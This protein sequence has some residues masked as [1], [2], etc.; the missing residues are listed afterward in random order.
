MDARGAAERCPP[1]KVVAHM[2]AGE[3]LEVGMT[4]TRWDRPLA[5]IVPGRTVVWLVA[6]LRRDET[7]QPRWT[8]ALFIYFR[9]HPPTFVEGSDLRSAGGSPGC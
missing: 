5:P 8:D 9:R 3:Q 6:A 7:W 1:G 2:L 4:E